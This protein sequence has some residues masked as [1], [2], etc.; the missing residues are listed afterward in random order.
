MK[1]IIGFIRFLLMNPRRRH[2]LIEQADFWHK[3]C[4]RAFDDCQDAAMHKQPDKF[5]KAKARHDLSYRRFK[6][7]QKH[8][9]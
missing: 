1:D 9:P 3:E 6:E 8:I 7:V 5:W 4:N 2:E